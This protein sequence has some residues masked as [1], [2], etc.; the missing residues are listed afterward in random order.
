[1]ESSEDKVDKYIEPV[2]HFCVKRLNNRQDAEDLASEIMVHILNGIKKY[3]ID[4]LEK[5]VWR[6]AHNRY[7]RFVGRLKKL[8][9]T[10]FEYDFN[11]IKDDYDFIDETIIVN[12]FQQVFKYLHTL[13]CEYRN[14]LVDYYIEQLP[15]KQIAKNYKLA[16]TTVKWRLNIGRQKIKNRIGEEKMEKIYKR[17][18]WRTD[19]C[20]G[21][22]NTEKYLYSQIARAICQAA[23]DKPLT[24]EEISQ[25][26]GVPAMYIEDELP[27]LIDGEAIEKIGSKYATNFIVLRLCDKKIMITK[28]ASLVADIADYFTEVFNKHETD[29]SKMDFYGCDFPM[30]RLGFFTLPAVLIGKIRKIKD[31]LN[32][33]D[34]PYP[35]RRDGGYGWFVVDEKD[36][37]NQSLNSIG[38]GLSISCHIKDGVVHLKEN[39]DPIYS[40]AIGRFSNHNY[41]DHAAAHWIHDNKIIEKSENG[42]IPGNVLTDDDRIMLLKNSLIVKDGNRYKINFPVFSREQYD[43]FMGY[44]NKADAR[45]DGLLTELI[46]DIHK[47]FKTFVPKRLDSQINQW[48][49]CYVGQ[50]ALYVMEE[51]INRNVLETLDQ[52]KPSA[53]G[54]FCVLGEYVEL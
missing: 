34:G 6:I 24:V 14:I 23:Y 21:S 17:I 53:N 12:E 7:A 51:L 11:E 3:R 36:P 8:N 43:K 32:M 33:K 19:T 46:T 50:I 41:L 35:P 44:F 48:V 5:W 2:F 1:M 42:I 29:V 28:F 4:S 26:T 54:V 30:K 9:E 40:F 31:E 49:S 47:C 15:V 22:V 52:E 27:R 45:I 16:E 38:I 10:P 13:S 37:D 20:N 18:N 25:R 39:L